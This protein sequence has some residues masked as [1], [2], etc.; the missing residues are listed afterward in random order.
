MRGP[1]YMWR[2]YVNGQATGL[3]LHLEGSNG[4]VLATIVGAAKAHGIELVPVYPPDYVAAQ[5]EH[6]EVGEQP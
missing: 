2:I 3:T 1:D 6:A 4:D 5:R